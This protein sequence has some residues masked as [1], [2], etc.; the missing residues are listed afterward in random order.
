VADDG[1]SDVRFVYCAVA[2]CALLGNDFSSIN[3]PLATEYII[4]CVGYDGGI[5]LVPG[6]FKTS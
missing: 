4:R 5:G 6:K 2:I 3:V 1:E